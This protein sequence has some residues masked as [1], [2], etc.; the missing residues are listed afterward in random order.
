MDREG[1]FRTCC[2]TAFQACAAATGNDR[3]PRVE[4]C[5][6]GTSRV[7][8]STDRRY[9]RVLRLETTGLPPA[10]AG[11]QFSDP[12]GMQGW[13]VVA[14]GD[15]GLFC[16]AWSDIWDNIL[17]G[18]CGVCSCW[19]LHLKM[20]NCAGFWWQRRL[21]RTE[22]LEEYVLLIHSEVNY[23]MMTMAVCNSI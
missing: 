1:P 23:Y 15:S 9:G 2:G 14:P 3:S 17:T 6:D 11:T 16:C 12:G 7:D 21:N 10:E 18:F 13:V 19:M 22:D 4:R 20:K 8:V 5:M